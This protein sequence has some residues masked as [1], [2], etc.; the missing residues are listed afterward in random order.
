MASSII[1]GTN[2]NIYKETLL[3][4]FSQETLKPVDKAASI[5]FVGPYPPI[6]CGIA[7]YTSFIIRKNPES[8]W[9]VISF[10]LEN[11][12]APLTDEEK[13]KHNV[14]YGIPSRRDF[15]SSTIE[16]GLSTLSSRRENAVLWFQHEFGIWPRNFQFISMLKNLNIPKVVSF[17]TLHFQ[18]DESVMGLRNNEYYMLQILLPYVDAITVFSRGVYNAVSAAFPQHSGKL[19][20]IRHGI[21]SY[22]EI[23]H[24]S[25]KEAKEKLN[26]YLLYESDLSMKVKKAL[27]KQRVF[28]DPNT[29]VLGQTG[30]MAHSKDTKFLYHSRDSLQRYL[31]H[32]KIVAVRI[33]KPRDKSQKKYADKLLRMCNGEDKFLCETWVNGDILP[34]AQRAFDINFYWPSECTQSGVLSHALG[35]GAL[36]AGRDMEGV[37]ETLKEAGELTDINLDSLLLKVKNLICNPEIG[38]MIEE[39]V[40]NFAEEFSWKN[41]SRRH[42]NIAEQILA[43]KPVRPEQCILLKTGDRNLPR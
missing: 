21:H 32:R 33:G 40:L 6:M 19:H 37:G 1:G 25:R 18:S 42:F 17:H 16:K 26:D 22:P 30:F 28:T 34:L 13:A 31:P 36:I 4:P 29:V 38:E 9:G 5:Y 14:W 15:T 2:P 23:T 12:G 8:R 27:Y 24:L 20:L 41:Q 10:N 43:A 35:T 11:Y 7:D 39:K 3:I